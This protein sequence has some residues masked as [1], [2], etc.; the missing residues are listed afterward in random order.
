MVGDVSDVALAD[1]HPPRRQGIAKTLQYVVAHRTGT[2]LSSVFT[3]VIE[4]YRNAR[5]LRSIEPAVVTEN[6][7]AADDFAVRAL[8]I[9]RIDGRTDY[10]ISALD[11]QTLYRIDGRVP[12]KG[13]FG[14]YSEKNGKPVYAYLNDGTILGSD[15]QGIKMDANI[16]GKVI[17]F[18]K[19]L[20]RKN[21]ITVQVDS[22]PLDTSRVIGRDIYVR[23][24]GKRS[25]V[26]RIENVDSFGEGKYL[27]HLG[28]QTLIR[29]YAS[30]K[31]LSKGFVYDIAAGQ[32]FYIPLSQEMNL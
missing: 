27:L 7:T 22:T 28:E 26:Y 23:N 20:S 16:T 30:D 6:G 13:T 15:S 10:V 19:E 29:S 17:D 14:I 3:S 21:T 11:P 12:F 18:T 4:P 24:D 8:K 9:E 25:A 31:D 1:G 32:P 5:V 2:D